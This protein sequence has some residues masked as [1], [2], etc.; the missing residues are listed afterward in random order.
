MK[1]A[2]INSTYAPDII[3]GAELSV[4]YLAES[5][6]SAGHEA[7]VIT[8]GKSPGVDDINGVRVYRVRLNNLYWPFEKRHSAPI[9]IAWNLLDIA[10]PLMI[11]PVARILQEERPDVVHTNNIQ[12]F[13]PIVWKLA[14]DLGFPV[15]HTIRDLYLLCPRSAMYR[16]GHNCERQCT[17]CRVFS[18][19]KRFWSQHVN[20]VVGISEFILNRHVGLDWFPNAKREVI[21]NSFPPSDAVLDPPGGATIRFGFLGRVDHRKGIEVLLGAF[22]QQSISDNSTLLVA[23]AG[24]AGYVDYLRKQSDGYSV[25]FA[26]RMSQYEFFSQIDVLIVPSTIH[27]ALGR[28]ILEAYAYGRPVIASRRG[29]IPEIVDENYTGFLFDP[30]ESDELAALMRKVINDR[31]LIQ[32]MSSKCISKFSEFLPKS[33]LSRYMNMY[34][35]AVGLPASNSSPSRS[36]EAMETYGGGR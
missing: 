15:V 26:G 16:N 18:T 2:L 19:P 25:T 23:G 7:V 33:I 24:E 9:R 10:N 5:L 21:F 35:E 12:G 6:T 30:D 17:S 22:C 11:A 34:R 32:N 36:H 28:V 8:L 27:E 31:S 13:S 20:G 14:Y 3:G 1:V 29:G 4:Q